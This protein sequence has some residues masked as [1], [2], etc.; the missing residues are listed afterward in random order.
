V[1]WGY[2]IAVVVR[3]LLAVLAGANGHALTDAEGMGSIVE[4]LGFVAVP[5]AGAVGAD[6]FAARSQ[7]KQ[8]V[9]H[10]MVT[11]SQLLRELSAAGRL[12]SVKNAAGKL[13]IEYKPAEVK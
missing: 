5:A 1:D 3:A 10:A 9:D 2:W 13:E 8:A 11:L 12:T 4:W 7:G 6:V